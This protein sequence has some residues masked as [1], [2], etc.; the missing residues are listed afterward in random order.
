MPAANHDRLPALRI[1]STGLAHSDAVGVSVSSILK[2]PLAVER[3]TGRRGVELGER[4]GGL[5]D[6]RG[7]HALVGVL[8]MAFPPPRSSPRPLTGCG[9]RWRLGLQV[10][11]DPNLTCRVDASE[12]CCD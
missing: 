7:E 12:R 8:P 3:N 1:S 5:T 9:R 6:E 10:G 11:D 4:S 2:S